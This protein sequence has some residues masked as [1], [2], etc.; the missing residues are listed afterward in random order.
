MDFVMKDMKN[1]FYVD[2]NHEDQ[3]E[4]AKKIIEIYNNE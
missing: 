1:M 2:H 3:F 4:K